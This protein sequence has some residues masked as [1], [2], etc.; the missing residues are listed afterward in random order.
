M[1]AQQLT[2]WGAQKVTHIQSADAAINLCKKLDEHNRFDMI[3]I[4]MQMPGTNGLQLGS[5]LKNLDYME[6]TQFILMMPIDRQFNDIQS[7]EQH[8]NGYITKPITTQNLREIFI[9][10]VACPTTESSQHE[11]QEPLKPISLT[12]DQQH[13]LT[14]WPV[15]TLILLVDD[16]A[17]NQE[18]VYGLLEDMN[19]PTGSASS[20]VEAI[21]ELSDAYDTQPYTLVLMDCQMPEM[22]GY[23]ATKQ[24]RLGKAGSYNKSIT[25]IAVTANAMKGDKEKCLQA[26]M[27]DYISKPIIPKE[28]EIK[29]QQWLLNVKNDAQSPEKVGDVWDYENLLRRVRGKDERV[30]RL[31]DMFLADMPS[32][33]SELEEKIN[34]SQHQNVTDIAHTQLKVSQGTLEH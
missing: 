16:N 4:D 34:L 22:D 20:G 33:I 5:T 12:S 6:N 30:K 26:G 23:E 10:D 2:L 31:V 15:N 27:N 21:N 29:L 9:T 14:K 25:I 19:I 17:I 24:I 13:K 32:R 8:F 28:L 7:N 18:V 3:L 11:S 1:I